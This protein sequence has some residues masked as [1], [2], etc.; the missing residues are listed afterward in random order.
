M[1]LLFFFFLVEDEVIE[2]NKKGHFNT[3]IPDKVVA[4]RP[5][6]GLILK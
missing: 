3:D 5:E 1:D 4:A 2:E 6:K